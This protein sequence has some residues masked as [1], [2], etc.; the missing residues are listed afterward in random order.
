[1]C[2][3]TV[4]LIQG[5]LEEAGIT[6]VSISQ[7]QEVSQKVKPPRALFVPYRLG[8][9]LGKPHDPALQQKIILQALKLLERSDLPVL[10]SFQ[11]ESM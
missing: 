11:P 9:P 10:A 8:Y 1:M 4:G 6:S 2:N 7:L 3:Q 5:V